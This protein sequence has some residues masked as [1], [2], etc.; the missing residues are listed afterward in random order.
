MVTLHTAVCVIDDF[1]ARCIVAV[2]KINTA[3][4]LNYQEGT[5]LYTSHLYLGFLNSYS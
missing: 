4:W 3:L 5:I 2:L 1:D